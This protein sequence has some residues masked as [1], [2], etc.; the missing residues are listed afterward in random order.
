V[1][2]LPPTG[3]GGHD[4][5]VVQLR[6]PDQIPDF[7][8]PVSILATGKLDLNGFNETI[9][10]ANLQTALTLA[11]GSEVATGAGT[12]TLNGDVLF[13]GGV[14]APAVVSGKLNLGSAAT[15]TF[16][17]GDFAPVPYDLQVTADISGGANAP[18]LKI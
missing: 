2:N 16:N 14:V 9:G 5:D 1:G 4:A 7:L 10:S 6:N 15:R 11:G 12:L 8:A 3:T 18:L 13:S 17:V